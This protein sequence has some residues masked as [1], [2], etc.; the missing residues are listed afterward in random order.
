MAQADMDLKK[1]EK[2]LG[3][4]ITFST[5]MLLVPAV[6]NTQKMKKKNSLLPAP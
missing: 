1:K 4:P 5:E 2:T 6:G 3:S